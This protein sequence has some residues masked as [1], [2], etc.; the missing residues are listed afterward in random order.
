MVSVSSRICILSFGLT[1]EFG[2]FDLLVD[3][4]MGLDVDVGAE[5]D[6]DADNTVFDKST[7]FE[8][9]TGVDLSVDLDVVDIDLDGE[10][11]GVV[12]AESYGCA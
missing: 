7:V 8:F 1:F 3:V 12:T 4:D 9:D 11:V 5:L 2:G 6:A 10:A